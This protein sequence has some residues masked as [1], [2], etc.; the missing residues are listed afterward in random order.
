MNVGI[1]GCG[2][3]G[4]KRAKALGK[5]KLVACAD[6]LIERAQGLAK[7]GRNQVTVTTDWKAVIDQNMKNKLVITKNMQ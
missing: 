5:A 7:L 6:P 2:L 4:Q 3:I 1:I